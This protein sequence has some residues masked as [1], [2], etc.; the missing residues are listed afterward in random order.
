MGIS[1]LCTPSRE[2]GQNLIGLEREKSHI[3][4]K[5]TPGFL[6]P[7]YRAVSSL[8]YQAS[9]VSREPGESPSHAAPRDPTICLL[10]PA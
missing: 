1:R 2:A 5:Q 8:P 6:L 7:S 4:G 10:T 3:K 9:M